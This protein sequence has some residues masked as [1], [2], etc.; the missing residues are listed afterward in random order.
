MPAPDKMRPWLHIY[1][2]RWPECEF[3]TKAEW[4][5]FRHQDETGHAMDWPGESRP[6][7]AASPRLRRDSER[8]EN[9]D[10]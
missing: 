6:R 10:V 5:G 7:P 2:K 8:E 4:A 1:C 9:N 3:Q